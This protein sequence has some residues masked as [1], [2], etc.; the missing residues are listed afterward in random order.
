MIE[1]MTQLPQPPLI[2]TSADCDQLMYH[3]DPL[4]ACL[5]NDAAP[6]NPIVNPATSGSMTSPSTSSPIGWSAFGHGDGLVGC[7]S[8]ERF[9]P[10]CSTPSDEWLSDVYKPCCPSFTSSPGNFRSNVS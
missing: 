10:S 2:T 9:V 7:P 4:L 8:W 5:G 1:V 3:D 6:I